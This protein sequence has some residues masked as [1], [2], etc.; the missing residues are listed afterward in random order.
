MPDS[1]TAVYSS[2]SEIERDITNL[3]RLRD[4]RPKR[5]P[6]GRRS[7]AEPDLFGVPGSGCERATKFRLAARRRDPTAVT[8]IG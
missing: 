2:Q 8:M 7:R 6:A 4:L 5:L 3:D 1:G